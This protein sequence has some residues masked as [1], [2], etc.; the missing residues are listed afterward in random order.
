MSTRFSFLLCSTLLVAL[1]VPT[2]LCAQQN[3]LGK[4]I[5]NVRV[6]RGDFPAHPVLIS[7][8]MRGS[9]IGSAY[10]DDQGRFG[11]YGL[12]PNEYKVSINDDAYEPVSETT[13]VNPATSPE[14]F[15]QFTLTLRPTSKK[16]PLP[17]RVGGSNPYL[18]DPEDYYRQFPKKTVKEFEKGVDADQRGKPDEAIE[19]YLKA[20][21]YSPDFY[22]AHNNLGSAYLGR[23]NFEEAQSQFEAALKLKQNDA[24]AYFN[25]ANVLLLTQ[26]Y[27]AAEHEIEQGL[28]RRPDSAF[29]H[30]LQG[31]LYSR[32]SRPELAESSLHSALQLDPKMSE[33]YLQLVNLYLQQKREPE[34]IDELKVYLKAFPASPF[35]PKAR[36]LLK[37]LEGDAP[38]P[39]NAQ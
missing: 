29:G 3:Q 20:L 8:E 6:V 37:R 34:A 4:I 26:H 31:S 30:F 2:Q 17:A 10:C 5:G 36:D 39:A 25:L 19:H 27:P 38:A 32:T 33:A 7:L 18:V 23:K 15:V 12:V 11:F 13:E 22:P 28:Q 16:D 24:E 14:N 1:F 35:S 9:P 21:S